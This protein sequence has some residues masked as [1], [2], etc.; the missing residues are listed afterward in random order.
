ME[1]YLLAPLAVILV[2]IAKAGFGGG[3]GIAAVPILIFAMNGDEKAAIAVMLP[4]LCS[5]DLFALYHYRSTFDKKNLIYLLPGVVIGISLG[6]LI[7]WKTQGQEGGVDLK[8]WIGVLTLL[9]VVYEMG[10][11]WIMK[12]LKDYHPQ[13]WHGWIFGTGIGLTSS[14]AH[15]AGPV[16][17]MYLLPQNMGRRLFVGTTVILFTIVNGLKLIPYFYLHLINLDRFSTSA[18]LLPFVPVGV[19][20]GVWM[21]K[22]MNEKVFLGI[23]YTLLFVLGVKLTTGFDPIEYLMLR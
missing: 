21:N 10:K 9:Y 17:T 14:L 18:F 20:L 6:S 13:G 7:L 11:F 22:K 3:V 2:G 4:I 16:A 1:F 12:E 19:F 8:F 15:A 5:C 23:I